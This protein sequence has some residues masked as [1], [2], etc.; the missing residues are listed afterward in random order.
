MNNIDQSRF[1][2]QRVEAAVARQ[3][4]EKTEQIKFDHLLNFLACLLIHSKR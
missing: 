3:V 2:D 1:A 4:L